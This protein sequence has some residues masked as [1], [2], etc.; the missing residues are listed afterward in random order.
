MRRT[1]RKPAPAAQPPQGRPGSDVAPRPQP[2]PR[3]QTQPEPQPTSSVPAASSDAASAPTVWSTLKATG[4]RGAVTATVIIALA[5]YIIWGLITYAAGPGT[6]SPKALP[7]VFGWIPSASVVVPGSE[8]GFKAWQMITVVAFIGLLSVVILWLSGRWKRWR[9]VFIGLAVITVL[10]GLVSAAQVPK[11]FIS[12]N[13]YADRYGS[14]AR[15]NLKQAQT[16]LQGAKAPA[17]NQTRAQALQQVVLFRY[18]ERMA[19]KYGIK[20]SEADVKQ[21]YDEYVTRSGGESTLKK[22]LK[23]Y[24]GWDV[25]EYKQELRQQ[26]MQNKLNEKL[27]SVYKGEADAGKQDLKN[28]KVSSYVKGL[29]WDSKLRNIQAK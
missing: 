3:H 12:Y 24:L 15:Y 4:K 20:V 7:A 28:T 16:A 25:E 10:A 27:S 17:E 23:D 19:D 18:T 6:G 8:G 14:L 11:W 26:L 22:Q 2:K 9:P 21:K 13:A 1:D 29:T 5:I